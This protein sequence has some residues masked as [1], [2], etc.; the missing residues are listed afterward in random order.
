MR[1][2]RFKQFSLSDENSLMKI[3]TDSV[4][5]GAWINDFPEKIH[6]IGTGCGLISLILAHKTTA[7]ID[8]VEIDSLSAKQA[9]DNISLCKMTER[10]KVYNQ[11]FNDFIKTNSIPYDLIVTNPPYFSDSLKS[12]NTGKNTWRHNDIL[13]HETLIHGVAQ[14]LS[15]EGNFYLILPSSETD[16]FLDKALAKSLYLTKR[17][18][19]IPKENK[20]V[21]RVLLRLSRQKDSILTE[22]SLTIRNTDNSFTSAYKSFTRDYYLDF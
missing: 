21:N 6:D 8:S 13:T 7:I 2:F 9:T 22:D 10:I 4:L 11:S 1:L 3:G 14:L 20:P 16:S 12:G 18:N 5:L 17:L 15:P 19:I